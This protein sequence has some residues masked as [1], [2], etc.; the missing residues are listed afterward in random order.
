[1]IFDVFC[2]ILCVKLKKLSNNE[3]GFFCRFI[4]DT[5]LYKCSENCAGKHNLDTRC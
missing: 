5:L 3:E 2:M 1:M 4:D